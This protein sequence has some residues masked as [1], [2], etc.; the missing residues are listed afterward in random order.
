MKKIPQAKAKKETRITPKNIE[1]ENKHEKVLFSFEA[2]EKN[3]YFNLDGTC[4]N[5]A[6]DLF[7]T[8]QKVSRI[9]LKDIYAGKYSG[10]TSPF[11]IHRHEDAKPP[12]KLPSNIL[13]EDMW[14][15][16]ISI[17]KGGIHGIFF[18]NIFYVIWFD[19]QHNLYPDKNHGGLKKVIPPSTCCKDRDME[20]EQ[21]KEEN[22]RLQKDCE[23]WEAYAQKS[24]ETQ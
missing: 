5:W 2:V 15:I 18:D 16:R 8:M 4:Q 12:C 21:L 1:I 3:E 9:A 19:P 11:R 17:S 13:L 20:I 24:E 7:D 23:F 10:K 14:Q 22:D 6:A